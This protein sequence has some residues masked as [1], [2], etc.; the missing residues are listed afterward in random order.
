MK[1]RK[2]PL[3]MA[4]L[5][6]LRFMLCLILGNLAISTIEEKFS[7]MTGINAKAIITLFPEVGQDIDKSNDLNIASY[8]LNG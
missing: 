8:Y 2:N 4:R 7:G 3:K 5:L 1:A 6:S